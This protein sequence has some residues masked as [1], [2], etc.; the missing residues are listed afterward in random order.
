MAVYTVLS[1]A[2]VADALA[3]FGLPAPDRVVPEPK[4][5]VNTNHHVWAGGARWFLRVAEGMAEADARFE[6]EVH[7]FLASARYPAPRLVLA[8]DGR[9]FAIFGG[10]IV[11]LFAYAPGEELRPEAVSPERCRAIGDRLAHLHELS[12][13]FTADRANPFGPA[14]V[15]AW[16][17]GL[18]RDGGA[19]R[20]VARALPLL[21]EESRRAATLPGAPRGLVH[22]DLFVDNVLWL[23]DRP[24]A[25]LDW[26]MACVDAFAWDLGVALCAWAWRDG[27]GAGGAFDPARAAA[28]VEGYRARGRLDRDTAR[29][30]P[31]HARLAALRFTA[32]RILALRAPDPG[33]ERAARKD[34]RPFRERLEALAGLG[35]AGLA[36]LAG[37]DRP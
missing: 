33:R 15:A 19:D 29:A 25:V 17:A 12:E 11:M 23:G 28:L 21:E 18:R 6:G 10:R 26:E 8:A 4:G 24:S 3:R 20:D 34:W 9:P 27:E 22:G 13:A 5:Y 32:S 1:A 35:D 30:L 2:D 37:L 36:A 16:I 31:S 14:R 7:A